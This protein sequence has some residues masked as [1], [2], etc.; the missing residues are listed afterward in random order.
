MRPIS[1]TGTAASGRFQGEEITTL[2]IVEVADVIDGFP[3]VIT[4]SGSFY[5]LCPV[6]NDPCDESGIMTVSLM[7]AVLEVNQSL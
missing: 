4:D 3:V 2:R 1:V 5:H 6:D 7:K